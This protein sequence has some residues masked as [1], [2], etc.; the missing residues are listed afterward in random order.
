MI[1][2]LCLPGFSFLNLQLVHSLASI[3]KSKLTVA[4]DCEC[5]VGD[6]IQISAVIL[7]KVVAHIVSQ[8]IAEMNIKMNIKNEN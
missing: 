6:I 2:N 8:I 7:D 5:S 3:R 1:Q 4:L